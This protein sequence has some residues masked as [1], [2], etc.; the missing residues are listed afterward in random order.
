[1]QNSVICPVC[2]YEMELDEGTQDGD[3]VMCP[4]CGAELKLSISE[5]EV[6]VE[7]V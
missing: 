5:G 4:K 1:M 3:V 6:L 2:G 7:V